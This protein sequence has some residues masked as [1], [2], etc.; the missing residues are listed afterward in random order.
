[1][2]KLSNYQ[3]CL[4]P[5]TAQ[6]PALQTSCF[7]MPATPRDCS[8][9]PTPP[10]AIAAS[11]G[12]RIPATFGRNLP[13][14]KSGQS[15]RNRR[16]IPFCPKRK[17]GKSG[18][19]CENAQNL[20][21]SSILHFASKSSRS[22]IDAI[23]R[24]ARSHI[25]FPKVPIWL[26]NIPCPVRQIRNLQNPRAVNRIRFHPSGAEISFFCHEHQ[27]QLSKMLRR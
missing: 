9:Q 7:K 22:G 2:L 4:Q 3:T 1:M 14:C 25:V 10:I 15:G 23:I 26:E 6:I 12:S 21:R 19:V 8:F 20:P 5:K 11:P 18:K 16:F 17:I 27:R 24:V 13:I